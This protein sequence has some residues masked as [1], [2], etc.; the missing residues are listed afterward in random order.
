MTLRKFRDSLPE[1]IGQS[2]L[3]NEGKYCAVG[4]GLHIA[5]IETELLNH[6][7]YTLA[8][9]RSSVEVLAEIYG[10]M[11]SEATDIMDASGSG[12]RVAVIRNLNWLISKYGEQ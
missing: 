4:W 9:G 6:R 10:I 5:G 2:C 1:K 12:N 11:P 8:D 3:L 7:I